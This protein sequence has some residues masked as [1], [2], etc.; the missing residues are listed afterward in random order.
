MAYYLDRGYPPSDRGMLRGYRKVLPGHLSV[1]ERGELQERP[2]WEF[3]DANP[4]LRAISDKEAKGEMR[5]RLTEAVRKRLVADVP[6]GLLLSGGVDSSSLLTLMSKFFPNP[7]AT[8]TA[9]FGTTNLDEGERARQ[10]ALLMGCRHH[11]IM[12]S[13]RSGR[14]LPFIASQMDEPIADPSAIA[15]YLICRR[16]REDVTVL[17]TGDGSDELLLGYPRYR[18][19]A[20]AQ[21]LGRIFPAG[22]RRPLSQLL[23]VWSLP[24]RTLSAPEDPLLRD[25]Y[26]LDH[27]R[28][29][30][31]AFTKSA[32]RLSTEEAV[33]Q[34]LRED[35]KTWLVEDVLMKVDKMSM[36]TAVEIRVPFLDQDLADWIASLSVST[37]MSWRQGKKILYAAMHDLVPKHI[38]WLKKQPFQLPIDDWFQ[39]E[40]RILAQDILLDK[41][42]LQRGWLDERQVSNLL[43][44]HLAGKA[45]HGRRLYQLLILELWARA[46]LDRGESEPGP[47]NIDDCA[48]KLAPERPVRRVAVIAPAGIGDTMRLTPALRQLGESDPNVS[49]TLYVASGRESDEVMAGAAP[50]DRHVMIEFQGKTITKLFKL[51]RDLRNNPPEQLTSTWF[52]KVSCLVHFLCVVKQQNGWIPPWSLAM[53]INKIFYSRTALYDSSQKNAGIYDARAFGKILGIDALQTLAPYI[54]PPIWEEKT[55]AQTK[56]KV[57]GLPR[58]ILAVNGVAQA[59]IR[60]REYPLNLMVQ[61]LTELLTRGTIRT[62]VLLG[63]AHAQESYE[64]LHSIQGPGV[65]DLSGK[66]SLSATSEVMR[67]CDGVLSIYGGLLHVALASNLPVIALYGPTEIYSSDPRA[68]PGRYVKLSA[69]HDCSCICKNHRGILVIPGCR[70]Q[71]ICLSSIPSSRIVESVSRLMASSVFLRQER[72]DGGTQALEVRI[73]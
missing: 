58:P 40:W 12:I 67:L 54:A 48:R 24:E 2:Y 7:V 11:A 61:A 69:Y 55:L 71:A 51:I 72:Q 18:L 53:K 13:P 30:G 66:L 25:R 38:S 43:G 20:A 23:P 21:V 44:E 26:W 57:M 5:A 46:I 15:T 27:E 10:T 50:V 3:P 6:I 32:Q 64:P 47:I 1:W 63:D 49:V 68:E 70:E 17:L 22:L 28:D 14:L 65:L 60:Q 8:Y 45:N 52:S 16:A 19:H 34:I 62:I 59:S 9:C 35:V 29:R 37:R 31:A 39:S 56:Q 33:R 4:A 73:P 36:A 42:T 41:T